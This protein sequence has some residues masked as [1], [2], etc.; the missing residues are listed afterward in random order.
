MKAVFFDLDGTLLDTLS[1]LACATN[2]S[3]EKLG[4]P[5]R[6]VKEIRAF[7]GNGIGRLLTLALPEDKKDAIDKIL[8]TFREYYGS[9]SEISTCPY[10]GI[11]SLLDRLKAEG[12]VLAVISNK[13]DSA[14]Q[15]LVKKYFPFIEFAVG[16]REGIR[17]KPFPDS[18]EEALLHLGV[19]KNEVLY[20]G[21]SEVDVETAANAKIPCIAVTWGFRDRDELIAGG[22]AHLA[23]TVDELYKLICELI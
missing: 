19:N 15:P 4:F 5:R 23:D 17:R 9:H 18:I 7:V 21:D 12:Y 3:L 2:Y 1:D 13:P 22:A 14:L 8:P 20:V 16:E 10:E 11:L 6:S